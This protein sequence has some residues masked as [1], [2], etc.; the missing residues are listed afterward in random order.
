[1]NKKNESVTRK[2]PRKEAI[3]ADERRVVS[4]RTLW[5][6]KREQQARDRELVA[7]G[8]VRPE[9]MLLIRPEMLK[10]VRIVWPDI[11]LVDDPRERKRKSNRPG[12]A[13]KRSVKRRATPR[14]KTGLKPICG[15]APT[16]L[17]LGSFPSEE[18]LRK[19]QYYANPTNQFWHLIEATFG[20]RRD[21]PYTQRVKAIMSQGIALWDILMSCERSGS[22]DNNIKM[23]NAVPND[24]AKLLQ[25]R[26]SIQ[27]IGLN[28]RTAE[29]I[30]KR[31]FATLDKRG[32][33]I[34]YLPSSSSACTV[35]IEQ[36]A[37]AWSV[38]K[39]SSAQR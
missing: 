16:V 7:S 27:T 10:G 24:V 22:L 35:K 26:A 33:K 31:H 6:W 12:R 3:R 2:Q 18:S 11:S 5:R 13:A 14:P 4:A 34:L 23:S 39:N 15:K 17:I 20:I 8:T 25:R 1:M 21:Q 28:G 30:F 38:L 29:S 36:K 32:L 9:S 19:G 37:R